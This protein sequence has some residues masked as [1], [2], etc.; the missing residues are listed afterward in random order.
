MAF[1][2]GQAEVHL[3]PSTIELKSFETQGY[4]HCPGEIMEDKVVGPPGWQTGMRHVSYSGPQGL[5]ARNLQRI[6]I[7]LLDITGSEGLRT[8]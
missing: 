1:Q 5:G 4:G 2:V 6:C 3:A 8:K 7:L